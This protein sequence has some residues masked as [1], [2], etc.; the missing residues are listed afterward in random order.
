M[1]QLSTPHLWHWSYSPH[2]VD[3]ETE[4]QSGGASLCSQ[5]QEKPRPAP[6]RQTP[7]DNTHKTRAWWSEGQQ[8]TETSTPGPPAWQIPEDR[9]ARTPGKGERHGWRRGQQWQQKK[10]QSWCV[11]RVSQAC[12]PRLARA[13][14]PVTQWHH[15]GDAF[16][17]MHWT[18][19][20]KISC[21]EMAWG[22]SLSALDEA[23]CTSHHCSV[24]KSCLTLWDPMDCRMPGFPVCHYLLELAQTHVHWVSDAIQPSHPL[25]SSS[26]F[27]FNLSQNQGLFQWVGSSH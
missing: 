20:P 3:E 12:D 19:L 18:Y 6:S 7:G 13:K 22:T 27:A 9:Q 8:W 24:T 11:P 2:F 23:V 4:A 1:C 26:P 10:V 17:G 21:Q 25:S 14:M 5:K 16:W 15:K